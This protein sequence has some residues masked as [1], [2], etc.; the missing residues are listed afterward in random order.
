[1]S[2]TDVIDTHPLI[3]KSTMISPGMQDAVSIHVSEF[4]N[5]R[6]TSF[7]LQSR[8]WAL[9]A[10]KSYKTTYFMDFNIVKVCIFWKA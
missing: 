9:I 7:F 4:R 8:F 2:Q 10:N 6:C 5:T 1:M 3:P